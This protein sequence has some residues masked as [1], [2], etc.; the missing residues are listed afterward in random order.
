MK[1]ANLFGVLPF[2]GSQVLTYSNSLRCLSL[3][4]VMEN[5][6]SPMLHGKVYI[7]AQKNTDKAL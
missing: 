3:V 5:K 6:V 2:L 7:R 1:T 4:K